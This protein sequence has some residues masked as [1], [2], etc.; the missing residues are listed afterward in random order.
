MSA[1]WVSVSLYV[2]QLHHYAV[3]SSG[4]FL[5]FYDVDFVKISHVWQGNLELMETPKPNFFILSF[6]ESNPR[7]MYK[8]ATILDRK[9]IKMLIYPSN[10][11]LSQ[12]S[13]ETPANPHFTLSNPYRKIGNVAAES[14][15]SLRGLES[16]CAWC[17]KLHIGLCL[18]T[19]YHG[20]LSIFVIDEMRQTIPKCTKDTG[21][22]N[23]VI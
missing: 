2:S 5:S 16:V 4:G 12:P 21:V 19:T 11:P 20:A 10:L 17:T 8:I 18:H 14:H 1:K 13:M 9:T 22:V 15:C 6:I 3:W 7:K 23:N